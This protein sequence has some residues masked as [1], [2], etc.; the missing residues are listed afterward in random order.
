MADPTTDAA[1][2]HSVPDSEAARIVRPGAETSG[3]L[4]AKLL[5]EKLAQAELLLSY[6][7][8]TGVQVD[9]GVAQSVLEG[10]CGFAHRLDRACRY[11]S[12]DS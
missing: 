2:V 8:E 9:P 11:K 12:A 10:G 5:T 7:V 1:N 4:N 3:A 6:A